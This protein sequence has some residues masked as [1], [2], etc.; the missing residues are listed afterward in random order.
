M[1][2]PRQDLMG[3]DRQRAARYRVGDVIRYSKGSRAAGVVVGEY[4]RVAAVDPDQNLLTVER[5]TATRPHT[6]H[7]ASRG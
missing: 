6:I 7:D 3:A 2:I 1:L 4:A 5:A